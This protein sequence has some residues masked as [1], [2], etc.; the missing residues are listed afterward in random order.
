MWR[1]VARGRFPLGRLYCRLVHGHAVT[2]LAKRPAIRLIS[3]AH[4]P[5][6]RARDL[7]YAGYVGYAP[8]GMM[9]EGD[10]GRWHGDCTMLDLVTITSHLKLNCS[11]AQRKTAPPVRQHGVTAVTGVTEPFR[12][13]L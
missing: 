6:W 1:R 12:S 2:C 9:G 13:G 11:C 7:G 4:P 8:L 3:R 10:G 5:H